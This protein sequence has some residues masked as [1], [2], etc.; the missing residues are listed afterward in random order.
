MHIYTSDDRLRLPDDLV[1]G[2]GLSPSAIAN[3]HA[4]LTGLDTGKNCLRR[5]PFHEL[6][7]GVRRAAPSRQ[8]LMS[9]LDLDS[10]IGLKQLWSV[11]LRYIAST[12]EARRRQ[13]SYRRIA[14]AARRLMEVQTLAGALTGD[15]FQDA[16]GVLTSVRDERLQRERD[17]VAAKMDAH[18][19][20]FPAPTDT[21][22]VS[23]RR[24]RSV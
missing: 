20:S 9:T 21:A 14:T 6:C 15:V 2:A 4:A 12:T 8:L 5:I 19:D 1:A 17:A 3:L 10:T 22:P 24:R 18:I 13:L 23:R 11:A 7:A 16:A